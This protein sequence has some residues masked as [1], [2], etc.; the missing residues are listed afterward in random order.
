VNATT[1]PLCN[2]AVLPEQQYCARCEQLLGG[3]KP[4]E[5]SKP[6]W[7]YNVWIVLC[8]LFFVLGPLGLPLVWKSPSFSKPMKWLLTLAMAIYTVVL[9]DLT[10]R[11]VR[12]VLQ[13]VNQFN[14]TL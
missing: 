5:P 12:A 8:M 11:T 3:A 10:V 14:S 6:K 7:Y 4:R 9:V 13:E 1:C 2:D